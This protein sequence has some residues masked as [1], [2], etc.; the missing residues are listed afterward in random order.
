VRVRLQEA[1]DLKL[2]RIQIQIYLFNY[3]F[4]LLTF[5]N[6]ITSWRMIKFMI[7]LVNRI[8]E[9]TGTIQSIIEDTGKTLELLK[10]KSIFP[11][12]Y[13]V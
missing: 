1:V 9:K 4:L 8:L 2:N 7:L 6:D 5:H 10:L 13:L 11:R 3:L 12:E